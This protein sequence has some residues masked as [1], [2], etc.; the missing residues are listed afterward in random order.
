MEKHI[1]IT[2]NWLTYYAARAA[3]RLHGWRGVGVIA[4]V[5][6]E[7]TL[8]VPDLDGAIAIVYE[9]DS[10]DAPDATKVA[11]MVRAAFGIAK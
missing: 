9:L 11:D 7:C 2:G 10:E 1:A 4:D 8:V 3:R 5:H 6:A